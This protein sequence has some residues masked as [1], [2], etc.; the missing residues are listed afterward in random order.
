M[1]TL[2]A[3]RSPYRVRSPAQQRK[4]ADSTS[5]PRGSL[6]RYDVGFSR[7]NSFNG[8]TRPLLPMGNRKI[9]RSQTSRKAHSEK[10]FFCVKRIAIPLQK[11]RNNVQ[12][13]QADCFFSDF[14]DGTVLA[15]SRQ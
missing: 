2:S 13:K 1:I 4:R 15:L 12:K 5:A 8:T 11:K 3:G 6:P 7:S 10:G 9:E 14:I